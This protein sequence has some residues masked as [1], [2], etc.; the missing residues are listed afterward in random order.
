MPRMIEQKLLFTAMGAM[1]C[2]AVAAPAHAVEP[3]SSVIA[4]QDWTVNCA[5]APAAATAKP[6]TAAKPGD[7]SAASKETSVCEIVQT[8]IDKNSQRLIARVAIG[9]TAAGG[10]LRLVVQAPVG[11]WLADGASVS[12]SEK[13]Q[14]KASYV[15]CSQTACFA[16]GD[17][18]KDFLEAAKTA[19]RM[20]LTFPDGARNPVSLQVSTKGFAAALAGLDKK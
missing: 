16:E 2:L 17:A 9:R 12:A 7:A 4:F 18:K 15:R 14:A 20:T 6:A 13:I 1:A 19:E 8:F 3:D 5:K 11:V 10:E